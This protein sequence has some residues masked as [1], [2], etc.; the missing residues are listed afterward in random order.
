MKQTQTH[1]L[2]VG[3]HHEKTNSFK[4]ILILAFRC[5]RK[6]RSTGTSDP[7]SPSV[8]EPVDFTTVGLAHVRGENT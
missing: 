7:Q 1:L 2:D 6:A 4:Q 8:Q 5:I 3:I